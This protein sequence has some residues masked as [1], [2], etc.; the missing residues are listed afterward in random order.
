[1]DLALFA[2]GWMLGWFLL[3]RLRPLP[4]APRAG[5]Q[6][7]TSDSILPRPAFAIVIPARNEA[8]ALPHLLPD[9]VD[10]LQSDDELIVVD[11]HS[12]D[13]TSEVSARLGAHVVTPP[14]LPD[15]WLGKP[16]AC[17]HGARS[18]TAPLL[19]FL[20]ADVRPAPD[21]LDRV[22][23]ACSA[24]PSSVVSVQPWHQTGRWVEQ[25][26]LLA[27]ITTLMGTG[28]F[29]IAGPRT[30]ATMAF[31]PVLAIERS[32][33]DEVGG[34][35]AVR[36][37]HTEDIGLAR[38]VGTSNVYSGRPDTA[39][40]MYPEGLGQLVQGWTRS[41]ATGTR[42]APWWLSIAVVLWVWSL[43]GGWLAEPLV[44]PLS[45]V[46]F[47]ILGRRAGSMHPLTALLY[48]LAVVVFA[49][50]FLRSLFALVFRREVTWK[51]RSV[52]ARPD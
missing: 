14:D 15:G 30:A 37:M 36:T 5:P 28:G 22:A 17:W 33:Y 21:L 50:I 20:D 26:S 1:V 12:T 41:I 38:L 25:A 31:G 2:L 6:L 24:T 16:H 3:W 27:N 48:P 8:E 13:A 52:A 18:T 51:Q 42:F 9:L 35:Q 32:T 47:W 4:S 34:H 49:W 11:D 45:A 43:A 29:T 39:F 40:R 7:D 19:L 23:A 10:Q 44:Y 46:Q